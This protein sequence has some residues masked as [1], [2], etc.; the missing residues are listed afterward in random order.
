MFPSLCTSERQA[1][2]RPV[3]NGV[4]PVDS[5][6]VLPR[7]T[8]DGGR[9][10][11]DKRHGETNVRIRPLARPIQRPPPTQAPPSALRAVACV[12]HAVTSTGLSLIRVRQPVPAV[13]T[14]GASHR[15]LG[16][17]KFP[18]LQLPS[19]PPM[20]ER[21]VATSPAAAPAEG[22]AHRRARNAHGQI[23]HN[24]SGAHHRNNGCLPHAVWS[25][26]SSGGQHACISPRAMRG[27]VATA[28]LMTSLHI[29]CQAIGDRNYCGRTRTLRVGCGNT[30]DL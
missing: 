8:R 12:V 6:V 28:V 9:P 30:Y 21:K 25:R 3:K 24:A 2:P 29:L 7:N 5:N 13:R 1:F 19:R 18:R 16:L 17:P 4:Q 22:S 26:V 10:A 11:P 20:I 14:H 15:H 23:G 27:L